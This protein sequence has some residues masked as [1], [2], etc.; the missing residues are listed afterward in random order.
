MGR[1]LK[2]ERDRPKAVLEA[3][4]RQCDKCQS[5]LM[6]LDW[7]EKVFLMVCN[8]PDCLV[9]RTPVVKIDKKQLEGG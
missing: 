4:F 8:N 5:Q 9:Y 7:N 6:A 1:I 2:K 3:V